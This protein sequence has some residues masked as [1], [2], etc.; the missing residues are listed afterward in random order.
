[1]PAP[2]TTDDLLS[3][4]RKSG[5]VDCAALDEFAQR[6]AV[7]PHPP[8]GAQQLA[9]RLVRDGLLTGLQAKLL[10]RGKWRN[11]LICG[12]YKLL[13]H[14]GSGGMGQVFLCEHAR[15]RR[16]VAIKILPPDRAEDEVSLRRFYRE[17]EA[18]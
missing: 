7:D 17:A 10:L 5:V 11:F 8:Q 9:H 16:R 2:C 4:A 3:L 12:K 14:L 13:E 6:L 1:M 18:I 15:M